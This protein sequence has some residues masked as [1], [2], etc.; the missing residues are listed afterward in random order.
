MKVALIYKKSAWELFSESSDENVSSF[1]LKDQQQRAAFK[2]SHLIQ[3]ETMDCVER[4]LSEH[5]TSI[6]KI[7]RSSL[8]DHDLNDFDLV[9][10][11]GGDGTFLESTHYIT[12]DTP[13]I[14]VNSDPSRSVGFFCACRAENFANFYSDLLNQPKI[15]LSRLS[16]SING[17]AVG[18]PILN[19]I[20]FANPNPAA[21]TRYKLNENSYRNS[22]LLAST[23]AGSTAWTFQEGFETL[24]LESQEFQFI[25]RGTRNSRVNITSMLEIHSLT[26]KGTIFIDGDHCSIPLYIGQRLQITSGK[27]INVLGDINKKRAEFLREHD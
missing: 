15:S 18:P 11:V 7:Y 24:P 2:Q 14:G 13:I 9:I 25:H 21:T 3:K 19:D 6:K 17:Q 16:L 20:L 8:H 27:P 23:A 22:G 1:M 12:G 10:T 26:R 5:N 4:T